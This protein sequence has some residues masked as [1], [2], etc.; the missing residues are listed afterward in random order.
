[1]NMNISREIYRIRDL[2]EAGVLLVSGKKLI[3]I[4][5]EGSVCWF[6]FEDFDDCKRI[7]ELFWFGELMVNA[8]SYY[9][10]ITRLKS[11]IFQLQ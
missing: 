4:E 1:M 11:R 2:S 3:E 10:A 6:D 8:K 9:D 7:S 5:K